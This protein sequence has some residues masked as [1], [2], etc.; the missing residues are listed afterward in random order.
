MILANEIEYFDKNQKIASHD[1]LRQE[2][3]LHINDLQL[4]GN[5]RFTN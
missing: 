1:R 5:L 3:E 2:T 4:V